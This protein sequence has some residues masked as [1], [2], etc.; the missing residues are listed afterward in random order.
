MYK[1]VCFK[2]TPQKGNWTTI[3]PLIIIHHILEL[4]LTATN[5]HT[6]TPIL[7]PTAIHIV[8]IMSIPRKPDTP[9]ATQPHI[10]QLT[11]TLL[12]TP[13]MTTTAHVPMTTLTLTLTTAAIMTTHTT[14]ITTATTHTQQP[15]KEKT[16]QLKRL[17]KTLLD[18]GP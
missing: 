8:T 6:A 5:I 18:T 13:M 10:Q 1:M 3:T 2:K 12:P 14:T 16:K 7:T 4:E 9:L 15:L 17:L 11:H